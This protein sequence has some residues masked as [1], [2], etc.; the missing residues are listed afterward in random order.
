MLYIFSSFYNNYTSLRNYF[1]LKLA[2]EDTPYFL[3]I[4][5]YSCYAKSKKKI[6][7]HPESLFSNPLD[8]WFESL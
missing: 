2:L 8:L 6:Q 7:T 3:G 5:K 1:S 4:F